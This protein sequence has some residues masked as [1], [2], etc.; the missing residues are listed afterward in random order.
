[1]RNALF[2]LFIALSA[3]NL[4]AAFSMNFALNC[5]TKPLLMLVL[6][7]LFWVD[8]RPVRFS[9]TWWLL[10][11]LLLSISG[12]T[13][14]LWEDDRAFML[15]LGSFFVTHSCYLIAFLRQYTP[16]KTTFLRK[17][18][19]SVPV[20]FFFMGLNYGLRNDLNDLQVP[21]LLYSAV[22]SLM[23]IA[24]IWR[25]ID[26]GAAVNL[27]L[28]GVFLFMA[29]DTMIAL[30]KFKPALSVPHPSLFIM[31][32]YLLGQYSIAIGAPR[33]LKSR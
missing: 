19:F 13:W 25:R 4:W 11:G 28:F 10:V 29:S 14:L 30:A 22:I 23:V 32:T 33:F 18:M 16:T 7:L 1:M 31:A 21:V 15:G 8:N 20:F 3:L 24:A 6:S 17:I 12:D 9:A 2:Y 26:E 5:A 27:L